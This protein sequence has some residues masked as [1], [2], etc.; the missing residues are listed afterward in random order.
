MSG[1]DQYLT[2]ETEDDHCERVGAEET[3]EDTV[4]CAAHGTW[5]RADTFC[6][7]RATAAETQPKAR[8]ITRRQTLICSCGF[9]TCSLITLYGLTEPTFRGRIEPIPS[10]YQRDRLAREIKSGGGL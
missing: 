3:S 7:A 10:Q 6:E 9:R 4:W 2:L 8:V 1:G 5:E